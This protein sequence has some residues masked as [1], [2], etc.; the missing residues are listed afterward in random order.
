MRGYDFTAGVDFMTMAEAF[1]RHCMR[2]MDKLDM[3]R[4]S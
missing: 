4:F 3:K 2:H 1:M